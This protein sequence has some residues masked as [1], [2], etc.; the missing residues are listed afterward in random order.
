M[1]RVFVV[2]YNNYMNMKAIFILYVDMMFTLLLISN[3]A[4][5]PF[6]IIVLL[7]WQRK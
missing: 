3:V 7:S 2:L 5:V 6:A 1:F 4:K